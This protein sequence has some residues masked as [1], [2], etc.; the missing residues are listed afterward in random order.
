MNTR[1]DPKQAETLRPNPIGTPPVVETATEARQGNRG[2][3]VLMVLV[4]G[5]VLAVV[6]WGGAEWWGETTAPPAERTATPPA[7]SITPGNSGAAPSN[8]PVQQQAPAPNNRPT[9]NQ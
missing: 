2:K 5:L 7:G 3:P 9:A 8:S 1:F 6:A 4:C